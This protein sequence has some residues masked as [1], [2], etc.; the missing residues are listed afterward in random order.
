MESQSYIHGSVLYEHI[1]PHASTPSDVRKAGVARGDIM[2]FYKSVFRRRDGMGVS[3]AGNPDHTAVVME[4]EKGGVLRVLEQNMGGRKIVGYGRYDLVEL[5]GGELRVY[6][7]VARGY[8]KHLE[9][10]WP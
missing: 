8:V 1:Y 7:P 3:S 4:V 10:V 5:S 6:R 9:M 2:Q